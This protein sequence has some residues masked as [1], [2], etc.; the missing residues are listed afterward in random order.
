MGR[1]CPKVTKGGDSFADQWKAT[2]KTTSFAFDRIQA[3]AEA[4]GIAVGLK[5]LPAATGA[6]N[7]LFTLASDA[8]PL[9]PVLISVGEAAAV[10]WAGF[11]GYQAG[12]V[13]LPGYRVWLVVT[14][15]EVPHLR[16]GHQ[17]HHGRDQLAVGSSGRKVRRQRSPVDGG[18]G[19]V[20]GEGGGVERR[21][22]SFVRGRDGGIG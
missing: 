11:A 7:G 6:A 22:R 10:V 20:V 13:G 8:K 15:H 17:Q 18:H 4:A 14:E 2:Q 3:G 19:R 21:G 9:V 1:N 16:L 12:H 5:L